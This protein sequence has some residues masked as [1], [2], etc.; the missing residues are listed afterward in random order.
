[1][2]RDDSWIDVSVAVEPGMVL[3]PGD[4]RVRI[5]RIADLGQGDEATLSR[6]ELGAHTGTHVDA[7]SHFLA[8]GETVDLMPPGYLV[9][10]AR[11][12]EIRD[13]EKVTPEELETKGL[14][15]GERILLK[16]RNGE[17]RKR[18]R[19]SANFV[20]IS[21]PAADYLVSCRVAAVGIDYLSVAGFQLNEVSVHRILLGGGV[22]V[23]E[24]LDLSA[25]HPGPYDLGCLP[26]KLAGCEAAPARALLRPRLV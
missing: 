22:G 2:N 6:L 19:F 25:V 3:W 5:E 23:I 20:Y 18:N 15:P 1:M 13:R 17:L 4:S 12:I 21:D 9:G 7:P 8:Q 10:P 14:R 26:L 24:N 16:T 11:V